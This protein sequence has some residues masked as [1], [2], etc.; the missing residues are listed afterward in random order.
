[1]KPTEMIAARYAHVCERLEVAARRA[2]RDPDGVTLVVVTKTVG[3]AAVRAALA[4]GARNI[5]ENYVQ[6][7]ARKIEQLRSEV[8]E[9]GTAQP[10]WHLIGH[11]QRNKAARAA[12]LFDLI[13]TV[14]SEHL[15]QHLDR[16]GAER[17]TPVRILVEVRVGGET[18]KSG[19][20]PRTALA[21][22]P[23]LARLEHL[24]VEGL[25]A[26]PPRPPHPEAARPY[27][28]ELAALRAELADRGFDLPHL[29]MGMTDDYEVAIEEG[30][31]IVRVG[32]AIFG[33]RARQ[34]H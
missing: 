1:M 11:L 28:H 24:Q 9:D 29:S 21:L 34:A 7:A 13:H 20:D 33:E 19:V 32:R 14:D 10:R 5:G 31:T 23:A 26:I 25:M 18:T 6:E 8:L 12:G 22:V 27:F 17:G 16:A 2:G 15:G 3:L 4:A 30:A